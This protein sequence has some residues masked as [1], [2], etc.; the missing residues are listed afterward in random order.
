M[1]TWAD[2]PGPA[3]ISST[4]EHNSARG[5]TPTRSPAPPQAPSQPKPNYSPFSAFGSPAP[6]STTPQPSLFQQQQA[7]QQANVAKQQQHAP[8]LD[9]FAALASPVRQSTPQQSQPTHSI[10]D[11]GNHQ[12]PSAVPA[13]AADDDEWAFSSA[14]PEG[15]PSEN[16]ITVSETALGIS[17][18]AAR[19]PT[20]PAVITLS[21]SFSSKTE[22]PISD[23]EFAVAV[24]KVSTFTQFSFERLLTSAVE[25]CIETTTTKR[26]EATASRTSRCEAGRSPDWRRARKGGHGQV[27]VENIVQN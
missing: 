9:P 24:T 16:T 5:P 15:L 22:Q 21:L 8:S 27:T 11:F 7:Q 18:H 2:L 20:T 6:Q 26:T 3:L 14:L 1:L 17:L 13:A 23:L 25:I 19:E 12:P 4:T 10:F